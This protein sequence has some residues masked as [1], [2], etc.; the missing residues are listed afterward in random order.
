LYPRAR[1]LTLVFY[2]WISIVPIPAVVFLGLWFAYQFLY[3]M[4]AFA[5]GVAYWAHIGGFI[6]GILFGAIWR[7]K[8]R[9]VPYF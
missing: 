3:G 9:K 2:V 7:S 8:R 1:I 5:G 4:L 6:A